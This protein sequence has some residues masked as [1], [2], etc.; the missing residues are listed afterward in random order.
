M[1]SKKTAKKVKKVASEEKAVMTTTTPEDATSAL[2]AGIA[3]SIA[4]GPTATLAGGHETTYVV[5]PPTA[6]AIEYAEQVIAENQAA[7]DAATD[8]EKAPA[9]E[10]VD[11]QPVEEQWFAQLSSI[12]TTGNLLPGPG[13]NKAI[14][15][16]IGSG[17]LKLKGT[18]VIPTEKGTEY[19]KSKLG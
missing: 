5:V 6:E 16:L 3:K 19:I 4:D 1:A 15:A 2:E 10:P 8:D 9:G 13:R 17:F 7:Q 14:T 18:R 11:V 12:V